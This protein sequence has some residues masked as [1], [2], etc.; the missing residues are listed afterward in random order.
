MPPFGQRFIWDNRKGEQE[1]K[2]NGVYIASQQASKPT[3]KQLHSGRKLERVREGRRRKERRTERK[4]VE[5]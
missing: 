3:S 2:E 5:S 4:G 1:E